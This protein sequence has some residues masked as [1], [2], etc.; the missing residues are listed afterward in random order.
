[1]RIKDIV[2]FNTHHELCGHIGI[3]FDMLNNMV[4]VGIQEL[5]DKVTFVICRGSDLIN[6]KKEYPFRIKMEDKDE[7]EYGLK[8]DI[9]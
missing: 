4:K 6:L 7:N 8:Q 1:M 3:V 5:P 2:I 9:L